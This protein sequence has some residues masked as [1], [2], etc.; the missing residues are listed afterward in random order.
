MRFYGMRTLAL[1]KAL[2]YKDKERLD[3]DDILKL[4]PLS[5]I[6]TTVS[7]R[8]GRRIGWCFGGTA[9]FSFFIR[10]KCAVI[11]LTS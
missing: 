1:Y 4:L 5:A 11:T 7:G 10:K 3:N 2:I 8:I 9:D 6:V